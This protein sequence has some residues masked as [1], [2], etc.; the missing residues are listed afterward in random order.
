MKLVTK[1][2]KSYLPGLFAL[3]Q[4]F[5]ERAELPRG[6]RMI[7][8]YEEPVPEAM[9]RA[10]GNLGLDI[11]L[12]DRRELGEPL[13]PTDRISRTSVREFNLGKLLLFRLPVEETL[14]YVDADIVCLRPLTGMEALE[15]L[16]VV[17][18]INPGGPVRDEPW[19]FFNSGVMVFKASS[20]LYDEMAEFYQSG[21]SRFGAGDQ[22]L[23]N[24][25]FQ[26]WHPEWI[27][28]L[29]PGW[30][31]LKT[32]VAHAR[33]LDDLPDVR[34][35]HYLLKKPWSDKI[36][37]PGELPYFELHRIWW[38]FFERSGGPALFGDKVSKPSAMRYRAARLFGDRGQRL[39]KK[40]LR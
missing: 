22:V 21:D 36:Y 7:V 19:K 1:V 6:M 24:Y 15:P 10:L 8:V 29:D 13:Q 33:G 39:A 28:W 5:V 14:L 20:S 16:S 25:F 38:E 3:V 32:A 37:I 30:N 2:N 18:N 23:L 31:T 12:V 40:L 17:E 34:L 4:S 11:E 35:L 27:R 26:E 9:A